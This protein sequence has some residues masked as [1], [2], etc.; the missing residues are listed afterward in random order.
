MAEISAEKVVRIGG[1]QQHRRFRFR[2]LLVAAFLV[3]GGYVYLF[4][5]RPMLEDQA[6][7][8]AQLNE[9]I[10][11]EDAQASNLQRQIAN[12]HTDKYIAALAE[13]RYHLISRGEILLVTSSS[14]SGSN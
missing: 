11:Q 4:V 12:L 3:W 10:M 9:Q 13:Q 2:Y 7:Q 14:S 5:Q 8:Q 1:R 6:H